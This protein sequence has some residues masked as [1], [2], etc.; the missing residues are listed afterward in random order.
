MT[1]SNQLIFTGADGALNFGDFTLPEKAK[2]PDFSFEGDLYK[3][4][5]SR[6]STRLERN[7]LLVYESEPGTTVRNFTETPEKLSF[8]AEGAEDA[9]I[10]IGMEENKDYAVEVNG[11]QLG[12]IPTV[13][14]GKLVFSIELSPGNPS[15]VNIRRK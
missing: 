6:D 11:K 8:T 1:G 7:D 2:K 5:T 4:K 10:T 9:Q 3:V 13:M 15:E 12:V 14:G